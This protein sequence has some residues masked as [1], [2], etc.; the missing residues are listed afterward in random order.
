VPE[1]FQWSTYNQYIGNQK[2]RYGRVFSANTKAV[3]LP[4]KACHTIKDDLTTN[5]MSV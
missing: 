2:A 4:H 3:A 1:D 5:D